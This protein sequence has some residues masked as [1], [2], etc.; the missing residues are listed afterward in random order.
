M[1]LSSENRMLTGFT[2][3]DWARWQKNLELVELQAGA[4]IFEAEQA[5]GHIYFPITAIFS[6]MRL[7]MEGDSIEVAMIG[8]EGVAGVSSLM[9]NGTSFNRVVVLRAGTAYRAKGSWA[10]KEIEKSSLLMQKMLWFSQALIT[11]MAQVS[12]CNCHHSLEQ[13]LCRWILVYADRADES[14]MLCTQEQLAQTLGVRRERLA[15]AARTLQKNGL[16]QYV[17]GA[18]ELIHREG[19]EQHACECY[20]LIQLAYARME[21]AGE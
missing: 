12:V 3:E 4:V 2:V 1:N 17:R 14:P 11:Q 15:K 21:A 13:R 6:E 16:I 10:K 9:G 20:G 8:H 7:V 5:V 19:I 18:I